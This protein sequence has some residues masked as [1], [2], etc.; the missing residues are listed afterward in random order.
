[1]PRATPVGVPHGLALSVARPDRPD[2]AAETT[3]TE[4]FTFVISN[5]GVGDQSVG[6]HRRT[7][8][9]TDDGHGAEH[10]QNGEQ[11]FHAD[12]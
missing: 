2:R 6:T 5:G 4:L 11:H 10:E 7:H 9:G 1:M 8:R 12:E 3:E